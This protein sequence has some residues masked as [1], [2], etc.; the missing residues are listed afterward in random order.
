MGLWMRVLT[1]GLV[2]LAMC[3]AAG[4]DE[5]WYVDTDDMGASPD[6]SQANPYHTL[7]ACIDAK[8]GS[9]TGRGVVTVH[10][11]GSTND[12]TAVSLSGFTGTSSTDRLVLVV[13]D[14]HSG[15]FDDSKYALLPTTAYTTA[16]NSPPAYT[17]VQGFQLDAGA[18]AVCISAGVANITIINCLF[19][20]P[21][22]ACI[23]IASS[24][25]RIQGCCF[26]GGTRGIT[27]TTSKT[28]ITI[29]N[30][31][32]LNQSQYGLY[33]AA[34][35]TVSAWNCYAGLSGTADYY[36]AGTLN[37]SH[38][39]S[40]DGTC[41]T[42]TVAPATDS[43]CYFTNVTAGSED[44]HIGAS[45][46]L[47]GAGTNVADMR[48][49]DTDVDGETVPMGDETD[50]GAD[51]ATGTVGMAQIAVPANGATG[52]S[53]AVV[54]SWTA[55]TTAASHNVYFGTDSTP[56][57]DVGS[58]EYIGNQAGVTYDP[59]GLLEYNTTYYWRIDE[60][61]ADT[62][63]ITGTV[64]S[65]TTL[66][67]QTYYT[68]PS[69]TGDGSD[70]EHAKAWGSGDW[71]AA[72]DRVNLLDGSYGAW[73]TS[74]V[75]FADDP[76][77]VRAVNQYGAVF[78]GVTI[79][80]DYVDLTRVEV[81]GSTATTVTISADSGIHASKVH[82]AIVDSAITSQGIGIYVDADGG[83]A[84]VNECEVYWTFRGIET[85]AVGGCTIRKCVVH[86]TA[87]SSIRIAGTAG[88]NAYNTFLVEDCVACNHLNEFSYTPD[89]HGSLFSMHTDGITLR[90]CMGY[91]GATSRLLYWYM[92]TD[93]YVT[94]GYV[95]CVIESCIFLGSTTLLHGVDGYLG[96]TDDY[97]AI[98][99]GPVNAFSHIVDMG[100]GFIVR[101][102]TFGGVLSVF[103]S[104]PATTTTG[105][106]V[107]IANNLMLG[108]FTLNGW[109][110]NTY[111]GGNPAVPDYMERTQEE[112]QTLITDAVTN[113]MVEAGNITTNL[114]TIW[115]GSANATT[116][117]A[118]WPASTSIINANSAYWAE[119]TMFESKMGSRPFRLCV[120]SPAIDTGSE[121]ASCYA[122]TDFLGNARDVTG[123]AA[124]CIGAME[125]DADTPPGAISNLSPADEAT[126]I[127]LDADLSWTAGENAIGYDVYIGTSSPLGIDDYLSETFVGFF[128]HTSAAATLPTL[129]ADTTYYVRVDVIGADG[130]VRGATWSFTTGLSGWDLNMIERSRVRD[131]TDGFRGR[132]RR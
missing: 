92:D 98:E 104:D 33:V 64:W 53:R 122:T 57:A 56:D 28:G 11:A 97:A 125:Y 86:D 3:A 75:G 114:S 109:H 19:R 78:S 81:S 8:A 41:S 130:V 76:I 90:R 70:A 2:L 40:E 10:L 71:M 35:A 65:F 61:E 54:L 6:G 63:V 121:A 14:P 52:Q 16:L 13:D 91:N 7:D 46:A 77:D 72:G 62:D 50:V 60:V 36:A 83:G 126:G 59:T 23:S 84:D 102:N 27:T 29:L 68:S 30:C 24:T 12:T 51:E 44:I 108:G 107:I 119:G 4:A 34:G 15:A 129:D 131:R 116:W 79:D 1:A 39:Y 132:W 38:C 88:G 47:I 110:D 95:N 80:L 37:L 73:N 58:S 120:G 124:P 74:V 21:G 117:T 69:G 20:S 48:D 31:T 101:N 9:M 26:Y 82:T 67:P 55:G 99:P 93:H 100:E 87:S 128:T 112:A 89:P 113:G 32:F 123:D 115:S 85:Y 22:G 103:L 18:G 43:G 111:E 118:Y 25:W 42:P 49:P 66:N 17:T 94:N 5:T 96:Q 127:S 45:S 105:D 106:G